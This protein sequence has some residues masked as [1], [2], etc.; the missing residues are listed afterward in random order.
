MQLPQIR[1]LLNDSRFSIEQLT[2]D[3]NRID[4]N[5][6]DTVAISRITVKIDVG[7]DVGRDVGFNDGCDDGCDDGFEDGC[8][9]GFEDG[10]DG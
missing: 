4:C 3:S 2:F 5:S 7:F 8:D 9:D 10:C 6:D 1:L